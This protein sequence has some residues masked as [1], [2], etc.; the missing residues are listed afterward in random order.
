MGAGNTTGDLVPGAAVV[1]RPGQIAGLG[2]VTG[3]ELPA[4]GLRRLAYVIYTSGSTGVPKGAMVE[5]Q[6]MVNHLLAMVAELGLGAGDVVAA[7]ASP[8]FDISVWQMLA[9][10]LC[11]GRVRRSRIRLL[12]IRGCCWVSWRPGGKRGTT[13]TNCRWADWGRTWPT[14]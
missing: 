13:T 4:G 9:V 7:T 2:E 10:L 11:G 14:Q 12:L 5:Q 1:V 6:G 8:S 3:G